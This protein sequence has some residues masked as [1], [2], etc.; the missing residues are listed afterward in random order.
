M[1]GDVG[2]EVN[3]STLNHTRLC[4][5]KLSAERIC[6][7]LEVQNADPHPRTGAYLI[8]HSPHTI[9]VSGLPR[10]PRGT[11]TRICL[12]Q[13]RPGNARPANGATAR[14][15]RQGQRSPTAITT[16][17]RGATAKSD[18]DSETETGATGTGHRGDRD[19]DLRQR[20]RDGCGGDRDRKTATG[21]TAKSDKDS[22]LPAPDTQEPP[23][24]SR[25]RAAPPAGSADYVHPS[26]ADRPHLLR[27][28]IV[29]P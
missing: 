25:L 15:G 14:R 16:R 2:S 3:F 21:A 17:R 9:F 12:Y 28:C 26:Q 8:L 29:L 19:R 27:S 13:E 22:A 5:T 6:I 24:K 4:V 10:M 18:R 1:R 20:Q 11:G 23:P 7:P